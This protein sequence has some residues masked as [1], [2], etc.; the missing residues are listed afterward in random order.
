MGNVTQPPLPF[1]HYDIYERRQIL[2][3][4]WKEDLAK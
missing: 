3:G 4:T 2:P 1:R